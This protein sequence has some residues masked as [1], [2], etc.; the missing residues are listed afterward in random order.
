MAEVSF[1]ELRIVVSFL[2]MGGGYVLNFSDRTFQDF[3]GDAVGMDILSDKYAGTDVFIASKRL[4]DAAAVS[5]RKV[6]SN[7][8]SI[9]LSF[10]E[11]EV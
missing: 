4:L 7:I 8:S 6:Q 11:T 10:N 9:Q 5:C 1:L 2:E 3:V